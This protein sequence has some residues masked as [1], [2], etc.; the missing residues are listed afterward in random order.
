MFPALRV[1]ARYPAVVRTGIPL[2]GCAGST[3]TLLCPSLSRWWL[4]A[5]LSPQL[6]DHDPTVMSEFGRSDRDVHGRLLETTAVRLG[7][8]RAFIEGNENSLKEKT[9]EARENRGRRSG[10]RRKRGDFLRRMPTLLSLTARLRAPAE[11]C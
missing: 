8:L 6:A 3:Y 1:R 2:R 10:K 9:R 4:S 5:A 11:C 7:K